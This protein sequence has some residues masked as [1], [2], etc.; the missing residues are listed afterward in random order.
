MAD[1]TA[2]MVQELREATNV[3][4]MECKRA[5]TEA[6]G[7]KDKAIKILRERGMAIAVKKASR[8][9]N[10]GM[11]A[12]ATSDD[13][14]TAALLEINCET[15]FAAKNETFQAFVSQLSKK[16]LGMADNTITEAAKS[17]VATMVA[18]IG[19]NIVAR[20]NLNYTLTGTGLL[21]T[22]IHLGGKIGVIIE[23]GCTKP[24]TAANPVFKELA[25]DITLH[26]AACSPQHL[27]RTEVPAATVAAER[28]I[29]A[30]Q[31]TNKPPQIIDKI[32]DGKM[33]KFYGQVC[34]I[35]QPFV[36]E[37]AITIAKLL[38][39]KGKELGDTLTINRFARYLRGE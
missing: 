14:K 7:D 24:E 5:L 28:E 2:A 12:A 9:A 1:I 29:Y 17:E 36:K 11:I 8:T 18:A 32:V 37:P 16:A 10:Q 27:V 31:V 39:A 4:M 20:R 34:L 19:E 33:G 26:V 30:K 21:A 13:G 38:E 15:D 35:E 6:G 22:Y 3:G 25:K 23:M